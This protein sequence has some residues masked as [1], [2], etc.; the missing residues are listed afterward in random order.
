MKARGRLAFFVCAM[1]A[2]LA[3][4][5]GALAKP[6][7]EVV[8]PSRV[9]VLSLKGSN[10]Y[11]ID[12]F[13]LDSK[14]IALATHRL[15]DFE[16]LSLVSAVY[17]L[18]GNVTDERIEARLGNRGRISVRFEPK[19]RA[20]VDKPPSRC[21]GKPSLTR[22]GVFTGTI[23][24]RGENGFTR[25][26]AERASGFVSRSYRQVCKRPPRKARSP[27]RKARPTTSLSAVS[28]HG[29]RAPWFSVYKEAARP[30]E[31]FAPEEEAQ[32]TANVTERREGME[33]SRSA[34]AQAPPETFSVSPPGA[35]PA[36]A[37]VAPPAPF[38]GTATYEK[39]A[40]GKATWSGDL[41]V[42]LPGRDAL[43]LADPTYRAELC[44]SF[45]C[46]CPI[47]VCSFVSVSVG[48]S[49]AERLRRLAARLRP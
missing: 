23:R 42:E 47:G 49:Q 16:T 41:A 32:Y 25:V 4:P 36:T 43:T 12:L 31:T 17:S 1:A 11:S 34:N 3:L 7:Y 19:G 45:A 9:S 22:R 29:P 14:Q 10:G 13:T 26:H 24:F 44:R 15:L 48:S 21:E 5:A 46:A 27:Q 38:S 30:G 2:L 39:V 28:G 33:I 6:G 35:S 40:G 20:E 37:T 18:R 8:E